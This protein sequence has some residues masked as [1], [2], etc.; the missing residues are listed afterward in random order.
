[1]YHLVIAEHSKYSVC[2][3][4]SIVDDVLIDR[5]WMEKIRCSLI[6]RPDI[7]AGRVEPHPNTSI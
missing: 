1:M 6:L 2:D 5:S 4:I 3:Y 7:V